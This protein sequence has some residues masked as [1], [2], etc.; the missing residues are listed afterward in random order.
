MLSIRAKA[1]SIYSSIAYVLIHQRLCVTPSSSYSSSP[2]L[3]RREAN[4]TNGSGVSSNSIPLYPTNGTNAEERSTS[5]TPWASHGNRRGAG[6][7]LGQRE[8]CVRG[9]GAEAAKHAINDGS[10]GIP[11]G[12]HKLCRDDLEVEKTKIP[13]TSTSTTYT[14]GG[15]HL[16]Q[17]VDQ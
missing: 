4:D 3:S 1:I 9:G 6:V 16:C 17:C 7:G 15:T 14:L 11:L 2:G 5:S 13:Y 8:E 12:L 10:E